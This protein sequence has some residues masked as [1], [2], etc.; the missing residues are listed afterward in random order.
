MVWFF[1]LDSVLNRFT[2][3]VNANYPPLP[4][5]SGKNV[6]LHKNE[7]ASQPPHK[8]YSNHL[9]TDSSL[10]IYR[11]VVAVHPLFVAPLIP[12]SVEPADNS[13]VRTQYITRQA[14]EGDRDFCSK[15]DRDRDEF[16]WNLMNEDRI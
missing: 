14:A 16:D 1:R 6:S 8:G 11:F 15:T 4:P 10:P 13:R 12:A 5:I 9:G 3:E 2:P 7:P